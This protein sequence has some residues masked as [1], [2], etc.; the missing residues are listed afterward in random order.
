[1][2]VIGI[3]G[4]VGAGKSTVL[5]YLQALPGV[6]VVQA[7]E[8]GHLVMEPG[9]DAFRKIREHFGTGIL[10]G[11]GKIDRAALAR[12]VFSD[13]RELDWLNSVI[14][15]AVKQ[16]IRGEIRKAESGGDCRLFVIEAALLLEDHYEDEKIDAIFA[17]QQTDA[18]F[19]S[20]CQEVIDNSKS[21]ED[22]V[23]QVKRLLA[24][25]GLYEGKGDMDR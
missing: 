3:T 25:K 6:R 1:M 16:W 19:R 17:N 24:K 20:C 7:D 10:T 11:D 13:S 2:K 9:T 22:T 23:N 14:H 5:A 4:G 8:V 15:P 12:I 21:P 18:V